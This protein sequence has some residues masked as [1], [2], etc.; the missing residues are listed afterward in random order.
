M[1][2]LNLNSL[3]RKTYNE[4]YTH[5]RRFIRPSIKVIFH[6]F[7]ASVPGETVRDAVSFIGTSVETEYGASVMHSKMT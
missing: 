4:V 6:K 5:I 1:P 3:C 2:S 7:Y